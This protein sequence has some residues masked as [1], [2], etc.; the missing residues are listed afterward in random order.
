MEKRNHMTWYNNIFMPLLKKYGSPDVDLMMIEEMFGKISAWTKMYKGS[1][2]R[3]IVQAFKEAGITDIKVEQAQ[4]YRSK[5]TGTLPDFTK[6]NP[7]WK[8]LYSKAKEKAKTIYDK[9]S[10]IVKAS[11]EA[12]KKAAMQN[13]QGLTFK[14]FDPNK[15]THR[16][17]LNQVIFMAG[18]VKDARDKRNSISRLTNFAIE[19]NLPEGIEDQLPELLDQAIYLHSTGFFKTEQNPKLSKSQRTFMNTHYQSPRYISSSSIPLNYIGPEYEVIVKGKIVSSFM[20]KREAEENAKILHG[21]VRKRN[22]SEGKY[23][24]DKQIESRYDHYLKPNNVFKITFNNENKK[25]GGIEIFFPD[26]EK[27][28]TELA[29]KNRNYRDDDLLDENIYDT[30]IQYDNG[31]IAFDKWYPEKVSN[32]LIK[33][34]KKVQAQ[35]KNPSGKNIVVDYEIWNHGVDHSQYFQGK[36]TSYTKWDEV[37]TGIGRSEKEALED[38]LEQA[39]SADI[40][41]SKN[42][43]KELEKEIKNA[44]DEDIVSEVENEER[45]QEKFTV[46]HH[47]RAMGSWLSKEEF[48]SEDEA[49]EYVDKILK[50]MKKKGMNV[51]KI[52]DY[53]WEITE[54]ETAVAVPDFTGI[55][56]ISTNEAEIERFE[57]QLENSELYYYAGIYLKFKK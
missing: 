36:G 29:A 54:P 56:S 51:E 17:F 32:K 53:K 28:N 48:E 42:V 50:E 11:Y 2:T 10:K 21:A 4:S 3:G 52:A 31:G 20:N 14:G 47:S 25:S 46:K 39:Y 23:L 26:N 9:G 24:S 15:S 18:Q 41:F 27:Y 55:V 35:K 22:P 49:L 37:Y 30:W 38:A 6:E 44:S 40:E 57:R 5:V 1:L 43:E 16:R 19:W 12:G 33:E 34:I 7:N 45:P 8:E 13:P